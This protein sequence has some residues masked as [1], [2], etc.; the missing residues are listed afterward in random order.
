[1]NGQSAASNV[2]GRRFELL[3]KQAMA[4]RSYLEASKELLDLDLL[5]DPSTRYMQ[6]QK[7]AEMCGL[8][9]GSVST[10]GSASTRVSNVRVKIF[11][12]D[13]ISIELYIDV[14]Y[15]I[16]LCRTLNY[17]LEIIFQVATSPTQQLRVIAPK[18]CTAVPMSTMT[19]TVSACGRPTMTSVVNT[20]TPPTSNFGSN[21]QDM[22]I[23]YADLQR[24]M[25]S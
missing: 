14:V 25:T 6:D 2:N 20:G 16:L 12:V 22:T 7:M 23:T 17:I 8:M 4:R 5:V 18:N 1:M 24:F 13:Y 9:H 11:E 21:P 3:V 15:V 19:N 10:H